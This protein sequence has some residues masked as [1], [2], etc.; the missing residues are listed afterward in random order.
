MIGVPH[1]PA[2]GPPA[3]AQRVQAPAKSVVRKRDAGEEGFTL[4]EMVVALA[5]I[6]V[7]MAIAVNGL[8]ALTSRRLAGQA[9]KIVAD[10]RMI[11]QRARTERTCYRIVFS[12]VGESYTILAYAGNVVPAPPGGGDQCPDAWPTVPAF[13]EDDGD[14]VSRRMPSRTTLVSTTFAADTVT[15]SPTGNPNG[16]T[17]TIEGLSGQQKQIIVDVVG[18]VRIAP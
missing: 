11:E 15:F 12:P 17:I 6:G 8:S 18:R 1:P 10:L 7:L 4:L 14:T 3:V 16:G 5:I 13:R 2:S 9:R